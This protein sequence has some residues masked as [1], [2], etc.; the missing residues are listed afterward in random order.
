VSYTR[1]VDDVPL[2]VTRHLLGAFKDDLT[3][4]LHE[5]VPA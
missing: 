1:F 3:H 5:W 4:H 2:V